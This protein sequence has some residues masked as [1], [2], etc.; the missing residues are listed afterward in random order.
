METKAGKTQIVEAKERRKETGRRRENEGRKE[1]DKKE[2]QNNEC[3]E[4][5]GRMGDLE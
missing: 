5:R 1:K 3:K 4:S 2:K